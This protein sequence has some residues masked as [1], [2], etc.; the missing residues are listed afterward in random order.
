MLKVL[1]ISEVS[2]SGDVD[3]VTPLNTALCV[4]VYEAALVEIT[5]PTLRS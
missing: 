4:C 2:I 1:K 5:Q 3:R